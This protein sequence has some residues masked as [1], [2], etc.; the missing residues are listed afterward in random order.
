[1]ILDPRTK[2][3][4]IF[5]ADFVKDCQRELLKQI[6]ADLDI[7]DNN[8]PCEKSNAEAQPPPK[9]QKLSLLEEA[10][11]TKITNT[12]SSYSS[13][14]LTGYL[15]M[16][17]IGWK[18]DPLQWWRDHKHLFPRIARLSQKYLC[19][20]ATSAPSERLFSDGGQIVTDTRHLLSPESVRSLI[21]LHDNLDLWE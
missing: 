9:K 5:G 8:S 11:Q 13:A 2:N 1:M 14:E 17:D 18:E 15:N 7:T 10:L 4:N 16:Q 12:K 3:L 19:I 6:E 21:F 20:P